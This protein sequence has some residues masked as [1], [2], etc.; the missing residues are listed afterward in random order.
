MTKYTLV[1]LYV[2]DVVPETELQELQSLALDWNI[3]FI[4]FKYDSAWQTQGAAAGGGVEEVHT[5]IGF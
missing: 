5:S 3:T 2:E 4:P 1:V